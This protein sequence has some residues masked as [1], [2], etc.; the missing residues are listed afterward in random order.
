M[1]NCGSTGKYSSSNNSP[2][3]VD[4]DLCKIHDVN[5][6]KGSILGLAYK[7]GQIFSSSDDK[8]IGKNSVCGLIDKTT[9]SPLYFGGHQKAVNRL[10]FC[11]GDRLWSGG[12][13]LSIRMVNIYAYLVNIYGGFLNYIALL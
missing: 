12:R 9:V 10:E 7:D 11:K 5:L 4:I 6:H 8:T 1:G 2:D 3:D 13:D